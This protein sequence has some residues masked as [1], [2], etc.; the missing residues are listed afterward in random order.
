MWITVP[1]RT[2]VA[3]ALLDAYREHTR[4]RGATRL[5]VDASEYSGYEPIYASAGGRMLDSDCRRQLDLAAIDRAQYAKWA[6][7]SEKNAHYR[8]EI[9][10]APTA[11]HL[12][13]PLVEA[14]QAMRDA[15]H[16]LEFEIPPPDVDLRRRIELGLLEVGVDRYIAAALTEDGEMAGVHEVVVYP[17]FRMANISTTGVPAKFRGHGLGLRLKAAMTLR[18]LERE[19][20]VDAVSTSNNADNAPMVRV[21]EAMGF[22]IAETWNSWQFDL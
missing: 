21:N 20:H 13:A 18:L 2:E 19:P 7:P 17:D 22:E 15:P 3:T 8:I 4:S 14:I 5:V 11:E 9:W 16:T 6:A 1:N 10:K 12:L